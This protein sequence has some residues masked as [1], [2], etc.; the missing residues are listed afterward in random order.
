MY[1]YYY[2]L[3][4]FFCLIS[5]FLLSPPNSDRK[6]EFLNLLVCGTRVYTKSRNLYLLGPELSAIVEMA[7]LGF[8]GTGGE[9]L[10][11]K[12]GKFWIKGFGG[13]GGGIIPG[14]TDDDVTGGVKDIIEIDMSCL[15]IRLIWLTLAKAATSKVESTDWELTFELV[16]V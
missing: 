11:G 8:G 2:C 14:F 9:I 6:I 4:K 13:T 15:G 5:H 3:L 12:A 10:W 16:S 1:N 7:R